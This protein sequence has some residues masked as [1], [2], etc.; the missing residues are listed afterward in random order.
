MIQG[1]IVSLTA[2]DQNQNVIS[3]HTNLISDDIVGTIL[4]TLISV[5]RDLSAGNNIKLIGFSSDMLNMLIY[6][7]RRWRRSKW[8]LPDSDIKHM[9]LWEMWHIV[10][11]YNKVYPQYN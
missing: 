8:T 10:K 6:D 2:Y 1:S 11:K 3:V 4:A 9:D 7:Y 5:M